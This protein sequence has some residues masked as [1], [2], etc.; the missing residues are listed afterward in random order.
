MPYHCLFLRA[1]LFPRFIVNLRLTFLLRIVALSLF[2]SA[3]G[4]GADWRAC[5]QAKLRVLQIE[6]GGGETKTSKRK[7]RRGDNRR[8]RAEEIDTWLWKN[9]REYSYELRQIEQG[10]M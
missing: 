7:N 5:E 10:R 6:R 3:A 8:Q 4:H 9:C 2:F 1:G